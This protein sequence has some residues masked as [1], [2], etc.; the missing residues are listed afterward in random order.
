MTA[1]IG[2]ISLNISFVLYLFLCLPQVVHNIRYK[3]TKGISLW[4]YTIFFSSYILDLM[5][6]FGLQMQWQYRAVTVVGLCAL[7]IQHIQL[8]LYQRRDGRYLVVT[9]FLAAL[10]LFS[11]SGITLMHYSRSLYDTVGMV[12]QCFAVIYM[13]PQIIKNYRL[14]SV[15]SLSFWFVALDML[16]AVLDTVSAWSL[17]WDYPS[18]IGPPMILIIGGI[19]MLQF[20]R[21]Q[22]PLSGRAHNIHNFA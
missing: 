1:L 3:N 9:V 11:M 21:Y 20:Y 13:L 8:G 2:A 22:R 17:N 7:V 12:N 6:G 5:Y 14:R 4:M 19:L 15:A 16:T 18:K 10:L